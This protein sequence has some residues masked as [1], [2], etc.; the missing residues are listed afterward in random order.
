MPHVR[1]M[2]RCPECDQIL[3]MVVHTLKHNARIDIV[4]CVYLDQHGVLCVTPMMSP[5][6]REPDYECLMCGFYV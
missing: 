5:D 6:D 3:Y 2:E 4:S 1:T